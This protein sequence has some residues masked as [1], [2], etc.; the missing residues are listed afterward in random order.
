MLNKK[1]TICAL[2]LV[3]MQLAD[4]LFWK[5]SGYV[6]INSVASWGI[7]IPQYF[8]ILISIISILILVYIAKK[9]RPPWPWP[10]ILIITAGISNILDRVFY[11]GVVDYIDI[12][13]LPVFNISDTMITVG[14]IWMI[15]DII[16]E[17]RGKKN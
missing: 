7:N 5:F 11:G 3:L 10:L 1:I 16:L 2:T 4:F 8:I 17:I 13:I 12:Q 6:T 14:A 9:I 15:I